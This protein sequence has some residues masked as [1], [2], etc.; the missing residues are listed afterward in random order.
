[1]CEICKETEIVCY[2]CGHIF[3]QNSGECLNC[4]ENHGSDNCSC[5]TTQKLKGG[6]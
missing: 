1:M 2:C 3:D 4:D 5:K 6:E